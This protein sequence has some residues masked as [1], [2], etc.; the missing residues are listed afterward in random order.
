MVKSTAGRV[1]VVRGEAGVGKSAL[2]E[3]A[4]EL[5]V[6][7]GHL[8]SRI[9]GVE[10]ESEL[11]YSGLH[12]LLYQLLPLHDDSRAVLDAVAGRQ[13]DDFPS[14]M[15]LGIAVLELLSDIA[16][17]RPLLV[18]LDDGHWLDDFS[19][20]VF[21]FVGRRIGSV[22]VKLLVAVRDE[23]VSRFDM[24]VL[25]ELPVGP[26]TDEN[27]V[28][29]LD[30]HHPALDE[31][32]RRWVLDQALGNPLALLELPS[33][34]GDAG[35]P[36]RLHHLYGSRI[37]A[38]SDPARAELLMGALDGVGTRPGD[39]GSKPRHRMRN[40]DEAVACG[41]LDAEPITGDVTFRH[42][43][44][45]SSVVQMA[46]PEQCR[47]AHRALADVHRDDLERRAIHLAA[48]CVAPDEEIARALEA[49]ADSAIRRGGAITAVGWL[50]RA[51]ELSEDAA[52]RARRLSYATF[53]SGYAARPGT[54]L[55]PVPLTSG[56]DATVN[57]I[58][59]AFFEDGDVRS[60]HRQVMTAIDSL[61]GEPSET[62][63]RLQVL[64]L[65][66]D[67]YA[68]DPVLWNEAHKKLAS[69]GDPVT[70]QI[71]I[72]SNTWSDVVLHGRGWAGP[73]E[74]IAANL[75]DREPWDVTR[76]ATAAYHLD[77]V[78]QYRPHLERVVDR[79]LATG[80]MFSGILMLIMIM[81]DQMGSGD[82]DAA[83]QT[84]QRALALEIEH[85]SHLLAHQTRAQLAQLAALRGQ[86]AQALETRAEI[87]AWAR[88]RGI[89]YI[90]GLADSI[91]VTAALSAGDYEAAY[92]HAVHITTPGTFRPYC[93]QA[94]RT[95]LD[96]IEAALHTG[97]TEQ[98]RRH[99]LAARDAGFAD[100]SPRLA[101]TCYGALGMTA[102]S[103]REAAEMFA[104]AASHPAA[105]RFP[106]ETA[107][108]QLAHGI[109]L[110]HTRERT[111][112][113][114]LLT[115]AAETFERLGAAAWAE[116]AGTEL[117][118]IGAAAQVSTPDT[119]LTWQERR[120]A[121]L[122]ASGLTNKQIGARLRLSPRTVSSHLYRI[123]PK[124]GVTT[125]AALRD[126]MNRPGRVTASVD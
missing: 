59:R 44:V 100:L 81:L 47:A 53:L 112:A 113:Q 126:A 111:A 27:A 10:V 7:D 88:P 42:P 61:D 14:L 29:L 38:L 30:Q 101:L 32:V 78:S 39:G 43:L 80:T 106:F 17:R 103:E 6:R 46:T 2:L 83:V 15:T 64:L 52:E 58:H 70:E 79:E 13:A 97:R 98:A 93:G 96:L 90:T 28:R 55:S 54:E 60:A 124:L 71:Q 26:L 49:A 8:V 65:A 56:P 99:A 105:A 63:T 57:A 84:G 114:T 9:T 4:T 41:L 118:I 62:L 82:W 85:G 74:R 18:I 68:A 1:L 69:L 108:I 50:T 35:L 72:Y 34:A 115:H 89:G 31:R 120:I 12:Q 104:R 25:P 48:A 121:D 40:V 119:S 122:A 117:R 36:R 73:L 22:P 24:A 11:P 86:I 45:R 102:G 75:P 109:R 107:R 94:S 110:R 116:R 125:R 91:A 123:F 3:E 95:L 67:Q 92:R 77:L 19:A 16:T 20:D 5:A 21:G 76:L 33:Q 23:V 37:A 87:D 51:A 66:I